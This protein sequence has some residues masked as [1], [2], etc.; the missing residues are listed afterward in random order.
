MLVGIIKLAL[1]PSVKLLIAR[2]LF[3]GTVYY[4]TFNIINALTFQQDQYNQGYEKG[5]NDGFDNGYQYGQGRAI[6]YYRNSEYD[7]PIG[8]ISMWSG[9]W[10]ESVNYYFIN[11]YNSI[12][13]ERLCHPKTTGCLEDPTI[14][15]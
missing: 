14:K 12:T 11:G 7:L 10:N 3:V 5:L 6:H 15:K 1:A 9:Y 2:F 8:T 4:A 13:D